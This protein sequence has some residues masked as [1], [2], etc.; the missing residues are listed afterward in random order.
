M[1]SH[2][3]EPFPLLLNVP[4]SLFHFDFHLSFSL[5]FIQSL[6]LLPVPLFP[7][8]LLLG[9]QLVY[10]VFLQLVL[11]L[12]AVNL[13]LV[14][15]NVV[16]LLLLRFVLLLDLLVQGVGLLL[17]ELA[18]AAV[19]CLLR[20]EQLVQVLDSLVQLALFL[21]VDALVAHQLP[22]DFPPSVLCPQLCLRLRLVHLLL[23]VGDFLLAFVLFLRIFV[24]LPFQFINQF[25]D[26]FVKVF[27]SLA[28]PV[29]LSLLVKTCLHLVLERTVRQVVDFLDCQLCEENQI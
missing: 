24:L 11:F 22:L 8:D 13:L 5:Q 21:G 28:K 12:F 4:G 15:L 6:L 19:D 10:P 26:L 16:D 17:H 18:D 20:L 25:F 2:C 9:D 23:Q 1:S 14:L 29:E 27:L 3:L 7:L